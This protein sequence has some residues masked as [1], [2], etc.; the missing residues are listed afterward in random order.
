MEND[1]CGIMWLSH[2]FKAQGEV[3]GKK[4]HWGSKGLEGHWESHDLLTHWERHGLEGHRS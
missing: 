3:S 4:T 1:Q 2:S